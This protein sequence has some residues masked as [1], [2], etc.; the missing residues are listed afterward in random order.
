MTS[1]THGAKPPQSPGFLY[2]SIL[3]VVTIWGGTFPVTKFLL[4]RIPPFGLAA[5]RCTLA[6]LVLLL[7]LGASG[8]GVWVKRGDLFRL[9]L[10]GLLGHAWFQVSLIYGLRFTTPS[11]SVLLV[12]TSPIFA[13]ILA[14]FLLKEPFTSQKGM[15]SLLAFA[16]VLIL[17]A[18][19]HQISLR[20]EDLFGDLITLGGGFA[21]GLY[22]VLVKPLLFRTSPMKVT[23]LSLAFAALFL[24]PLGLGELFDVSWNTLSPLSWTGVFYISFLSLAFNYILW[25][26]A[27]SKLDVARVTAFHYLT[28]AITVFFSAFVAKEPITLPLIVGGLFVIAG[29]ALAQQG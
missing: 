12:N 20:R 11:H 27:L 1:P 15:G 21:F 5:L 19:E 10:L 29:A 23:A 16:G 18:G 22:N 2:A 13:A 3:L 17:V 24:L 6:S 9:A 8:E 14:A 4:R 25:N 7:Y 28:P 26:R